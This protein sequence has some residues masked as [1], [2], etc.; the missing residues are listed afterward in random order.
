MRFL[1][2]AAGRSV[3]VKATICAGSTPSSMRKDTLREIASVSPAPAQAMTWRWL[4]RWAMTFFCSGDGTN[5]VVGM[6][7]DLE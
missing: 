4:P 2:P 7:V 5:G 6:V 1:R 3:K